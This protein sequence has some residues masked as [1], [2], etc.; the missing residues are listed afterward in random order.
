MSVG[1]Y[2]SSE[3]YLLIYQSLDAN[4]ESRLE[5]E[6]I[7]SANSICLPLMFTLKGNITGNQRVVSASKNR[8][9]Q[10]AFDFL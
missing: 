7:A 3:A 1:Y 2:A 8:Q 5:E 9:R 10:N 4:A 6:L